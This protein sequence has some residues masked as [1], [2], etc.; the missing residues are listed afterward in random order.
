[1]HPIHPSDQ[2]SA[3]TGC[4][5]APRKSTRSLISRSVAFHRVWQTQLLTSYAQPGATNIKKNMHLH[6]FYISIADWLTSR[7]P[8]LRSLNS[9][10]GAIH[11]LNYLI[12]PL[13]PQR[14]TTV[15]LR[16]SLFRSIEWDSVGVLPFFCSGDQSGTA[17]L[18]AGWPLA[19]TQSEVT[20]IIKGF[21]HY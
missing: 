20:V 7:P 15:D 18:T 12:P 16:Q 3:H 17:R 4:L 21:N 14:N 11:P 13:G 9:D 2:S 5:A 8:S 6:I 1:M 10:P 19:R